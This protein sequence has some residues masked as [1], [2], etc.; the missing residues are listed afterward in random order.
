VSSHDYAYGWIA[1]EYNEV[2]VMVVVNNQRI[3]I[4]RD[5]G[6]EDWTRISTLVVPSTSRY[7]I[8]GSPEPFTA[9][10]KSYISL[11]VKGQ[12]VYAPAE[13]WVLGIDGGRDRL[14]T[15]EEG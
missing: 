2:L 4:Y 1:P 15:L 11:V 9:G 10:G 13:A 3:D 14:R 12:D 6:K 8:I 5:T 7:S